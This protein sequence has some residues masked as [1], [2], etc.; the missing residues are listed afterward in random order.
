MSWP[1][2]YDR[3]ACATMFSLFWAGDRLAPGMEAF[4]VGKGRSIQDV[5]QT[6]YIDAMVR[7]A[8]RL[9]DVPSVMGFETMNEPHPG[10]IGRADLR[11]VPPPP[12][13]AGSNV[14][15]QLRSASG[16]WK[17]GE[18]LWSKAGLW[19]P[20]TG[21]VLD[22]ARFQCGDFMS[23]FFGPFVRR[24]ARAI[25]DVMPNA[26][27]FVCPPAFGPESR[28][29]FPGNLPEGSAWAPHFYD[30]VLLVGKTWTPSFGIEEPS[31][32]E[33]VLGGLL[34]SPSIRPVVGLEE[35]IKAYRRQVLWKSELGGNRNP[36]F[37]G[38]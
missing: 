16:I 35:R 27:T 18:C 24:Y 3:L 21:E 10:W 5:L 17:D 38:E 28:Q 12:I 33:K 8:S 34:P 11:E 15:D 30:G 26:C 9:A 32:K 23:E 29:D 20:A 2:N 1:G 25:K 22:S 14:V 13:S 7:V 31:P 6:A 37:L 4:G 36:V 19:D